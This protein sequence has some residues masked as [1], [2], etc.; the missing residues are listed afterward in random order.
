MTQKQFAALSSVFGMIFGAAGCGGGGTE[1]I[2]LPPAVRVTREAPP[3]T[4]PQPGSQPAYKA[5]Q[6]IVALRA[7]TSAPEAA[8]VGLVSKYNL[9]TT[10][11]QLQSDRFYLLIVPNGVDIPGLAAALQTEEVVEASDPNYLVSLF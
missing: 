1:S 8:I 7:G 3:E 4:G 11:Y 2:G 9:G 6:V 10:A 5:N